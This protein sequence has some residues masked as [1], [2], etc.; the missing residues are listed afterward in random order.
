MTYYEFRHWI[1]YDKIE[2]L[3][4]FRGDYQAALIALTIANSNR[5]RD[6]RPFRLSDFLLK[7]ELKDD[8][9]VE[10]ALNALYDR[11]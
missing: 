11:L 10:D 6:T 1:A 5:S 2:P 9:H 4:P 7:F 8:N 3:E